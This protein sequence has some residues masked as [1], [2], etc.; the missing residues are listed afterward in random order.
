[1]VEDPHLL[2]VIKELDFSSLDSMATLNEREKIILTTTGSIFK[3]MMDR[4]A[5]LEGGGS[6]LD[7][8]EEEDM[9]KL[10]SFNEDVL[11]SLIEY[12]KRGFT[13]THK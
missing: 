5:V 12:Q 10:H 4:R 11:K 1:M 13:E 6:S 8:G 2:K 9:S 3:K 7:P